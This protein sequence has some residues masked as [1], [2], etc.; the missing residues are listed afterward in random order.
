MIKAK[1]YTQF[2]SVP[3]I[4]SWTTRRATGGEP[5][6]PDP[7]HLKPRPVVLDHGTEIVVGDLF[8][9]SHLLG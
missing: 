1:K 4:I 5:N 9:R 7:K 8:Y 2:Q 3:N 6:E